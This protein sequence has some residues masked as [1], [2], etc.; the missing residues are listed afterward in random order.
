MISAGLLISKSSRLFTKNFWGFS[1]LWYRCMQKHNDAIKTSGHSSLENYTF[2][3]IERVVCERELETEQNCNILTPFF[4]LSQ[5]FFPALLGCSTGGL[6]PSLSAESWFPFQHLF[7]NSNC[8]IGCPEGPLCWVLVLSTASYLQLTDFLSSPGLYNWSPS[9]FFLWAS[10]IALNSTHPR[11]RLYPDI[12]RPDAPV[13]YISA[14]PIL[15]AWTGRRSI[16]NSWQKNDTGNTK[17]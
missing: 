16:C 11:S 14:F 1:V 13:I 3:F 12:P 7:S 10:Q 9:T 4:W 5:P 2:H 17:R 8:S 6:G 15:T